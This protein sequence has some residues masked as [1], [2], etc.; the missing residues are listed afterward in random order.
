VGKA[1]SHEAND[2][3]RRDGRRARVGAY[4]GR[5]AA[6]AIR[7]VPRR[8]GARGDPSLRYSHLEVEDTWT[9]DDI[10]AFAATG[11]KAWR[12][13]K[14]AKR[15]SVEGAAEAARLARR[16]KALQGNGLSPIEQ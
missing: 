1:E 14:E 2:R 15:L 9:D 13:D 10:A 3:H 12:A 8:C 6:R 7:P 5:A 16:A 4:D 11:R